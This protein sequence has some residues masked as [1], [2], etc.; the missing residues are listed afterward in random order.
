DRLR[1]VESRRPAARAP[2]L[3]SPPNEEE[4]LRGYSETLIRKLEEKTLQLEESNRSLQQD[5]A[6]RELA[7]K[8]LRESEANFRSLTEAIPQLVWIIGADGAN[9]F[10]NQRWVE[11]TGLSLEQ[12][13]GDGWI[14]AFHPD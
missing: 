8:A 12:S 5:I 4:L 6:A 10:C 3:S 7:E 13:R 11:F 1:A 14:R 9:V 2:T